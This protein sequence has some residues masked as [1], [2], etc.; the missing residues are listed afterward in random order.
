MLGTTW[1]LS[2]EVTSWNAGDD[3][4]PADLRLRDCDE[5]AMAW[6]NSETVGSFRILNNLSDVPGSVA[7]IV[8]DHIDDAF[9]FSMQ[10]NDAVM[11]VAS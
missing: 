3:D 11:H 1:S 9:R 2:V 5:N 10:F 6:L 4:Q 7:V 8:F